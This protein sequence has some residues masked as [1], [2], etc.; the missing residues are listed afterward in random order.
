MSEG[1]KLLHSKNKETGEVVQEKYIGSIGVIICLNPLVY[2]P[3]DPN[4]G[5]GFITSEVIDKGYHDGVWIIETLNS[6]YVFQRIE[7]REACC[8]YAVDDCYSN[9]QRAYAG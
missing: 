3:K 1:W 9:S 6:Y 5:S 4:I 7:Q 8:V 2:V